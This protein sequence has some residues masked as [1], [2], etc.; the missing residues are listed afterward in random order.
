MRRSALAGLVQIILVNGTRFVKHQVYEPKRQQASKET[1]P[2]TKLT[3]R[4]SASHSGPQRKISNDLK[5]IPQLNKSLKKTDF[6]L[7]FER[8]LQFVHPTNLEEIQFSR[9]YKLLNRFD[10]PSLIQVTSSNSG[11]MACEPSNFSCFFQSI[12]SLARCTM[13]PPS[14]KLLKPVPRLRIA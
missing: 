6:C 10:L 4:D 11:S 13:S 12:S 14:I 8:L 3:Q 9:P 2:N 1:I 7:C 5:N